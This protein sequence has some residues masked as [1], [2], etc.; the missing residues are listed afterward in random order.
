MKPL[1]LILEN[2]MVFSGCSFGHCGDVIGE[3]V[4][5]TGMT[6]YLETLTDQSYHGQ[7]VLQTFPLIGNYGVISQDLESPSGGP[8]AYIVKTPCGHP[9]NFRSEG[10]LDTFL[11]AQS[12]VGLYGIDTRALT[13][14]IREQGVMNGRLTTKRPDDVSR[15]AI[16]AYAV[17]QAVSAV[18][19][20]QPVLHRSEKRRFTVALL[21]FGVKENMKRELL[22]RGCDVWVLPADTA[23]DEVMQRNPDGVMLSNGP[24]DPAD[25]PLIIDHLRQLIRTGLPVFGICLGHQLLALAHGFKTQKLKYGHRGANQPVRDTQSGRVYISSQNHGYAVRNESIDPDTAALWFVNANDQTCEGIRYRDIPAFS[26]QFHPE[27]CG[28]PMDTA[29][30]FD[31]FVNQME[32]CSHATR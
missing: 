1:H 17:R 7:I 4:F 10:R 32:V 15:E 19:C 9:S 11:K 3:I 20:P 24:G 8:L 28:G 29:W 5:A 30:L 27:G 16:R 6:G 13:K 2:G 23:P 25:N 21:D 22:R 14:V 18:T 31:L 12:I 26:V